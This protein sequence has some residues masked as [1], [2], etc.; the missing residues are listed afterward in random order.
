RMARRRSSRFR[1]RGTIASS[2]TRCWR[3]RSRPKRWRGN[4]KETVPLPDLTGKRM[5]NHKPVGRRKFLKSTAF[6]IGAGQFWRAGMGALPD[7]PQTEAHTGRGRQTLSL[8]GEWEID[9]SV[10]P[11]Q[12]PTVYCHRVPVPGLAH[13]ATPAFPDVDLFQSREN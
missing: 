7:N 5:R 9:D 11:D 10:S 2:P 13:L 1:I 4:W 8:D 3:L 12:L 6:V